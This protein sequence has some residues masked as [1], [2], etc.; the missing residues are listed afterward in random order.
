MIING[1]KNYED[2]C[3]NAINSRAMNLH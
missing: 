3:N 1:K 2:V